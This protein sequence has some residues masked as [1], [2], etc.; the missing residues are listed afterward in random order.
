MQP[1]WAGGRA[2]TVRRWLEL[3]DRRPRAPYFAAIAAHGALIFALLGR[4]SEAQRWTGVAESLPA[5]GALPDGNTVAGTLAYLR[6]LLCR[7]G[8]AA[9]SQDAALALEGLSP[10]SPYRAT[11]VHA[12]AMSSLLQGD[13]ERADT[14]L[15]HAHDLATGFGA[16]PLAA[17]ILAQQSILAAARGDGA[18]A[19][20]LVD[21]SLEIVEA[22]HYETYWTSALVFAAAAR[23][24]AHR[25]NTSLAHELVQRAANLRPLLTYHLPVVSVQALL[26]LAHAYLAVTDTAG[27]TAALTQA[28]DILRQ[29]PGLGTLA[30][31]VAHLHAS[32]D[33]ITSTPALGVSALTTAELRLLPLLPTHLSL[34]EIAGRLFVSPHTVRTQ[35]KSVYR[36]LGVSSRGEVVDL[37]DEMDMPRGPSTQRIIVR[38][39][40]RQGD[41]L[42][43]P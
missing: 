5:T 23:S 25:G 16:A 7:D 39:A 3:L 9:M 43:A 6:T 13:T 17:L 31:D 37:L 12:Q 19:D 30:T 1:V 27:A 42:R 2:E 32:L 8:P 11:M 36:K 38:G 4:A 40:D 24:A 22:G 15:T 29:R 34:P 10:A 21:R 26:E 28:H 41:P 18:G 20:A 33:R 35:V 14:L